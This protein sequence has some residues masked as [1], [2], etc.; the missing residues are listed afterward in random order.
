[1]ALALGVEVR[2]GVRVEVAVGVRLGIGLWFG[3]GCGLEFGLG[4][5]PQIFLIGTIPPNPPFI[6]TPPSHR[7][8]TPLS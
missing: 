4:V 1:M 7:Y 6:G 3:L 8:S 5:Y 2:V